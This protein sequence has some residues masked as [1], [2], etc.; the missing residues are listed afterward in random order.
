MNSSDGHADLVLLRRFE[1][2]IRFNRGELFYPVDV[3]V[4]LIHTD[5]LL[6]R[7]GED[8]TVLIPRPHATQEAIAGCDKDIYAG[9]LHLRLVDRPLNTLQLV[10][11]HARSDLREFRKGVTRH[12]RVGLVA[13]LL[14]VVFR[15]SLLVRGRV[16]G[17][18]AAAAA[19]TYEAMRE[20][21]PSPV[22]YGRVERTHDYTSLQYW[23]F[24][25]YND[26]RS[27]FHGA[28]DH[29]G[30]WEM[31]SVFLSHNEG[32]API[33]EWAAFAAHDGKGADL[34]RRWDDPE[35]RKVGEHPIV[36]AGAG[37]HAAHFSPG[38]YIIRARIPLLARLERAIATVKSVW[39]TA[40][41]QGGTSRA[42]R[43]GH[44]DVA[45]VDYARGDGRCIGPGTEI[46]W[47]ARLLDEQPAL[48]HYPGLWGRYLDDPI[49]GEDAPA[50]PR[51]NRDGSVRTAWY[52]PVGWSELTA[53]PSTSR[54]IPAAQAE[55]TR[56]NEEAAALGPRI[57]RAE[58]EATRLGVRVAAL[59]DGSPS[60]RH[61]DEC[62]GRLAEAR[63][64]V[65]R[66][67]HSLSETELLARSI[68]TRVERLK[69]G[70]RG[71]PRAHLRRPDVPQQ[72]S[73]LRLHRLAETWSAI[74][75]GLLLLVI[76]TV[77]IVYHAALLPFLLLFAAFLF[78]ESL[79]HR[80]V[81]AL[82]HG[83]VMTLALT[84]LAVLAYEF[85]WQIAV[86]LALGLGAAIT[87]TNLRELTRR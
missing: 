31:V 25:A 77:T 67:R 58:D 30:D 46:P 52:D 4:F 2:Q 35:L 73:Q 3:D 59:R 85:W 22:Y 63:E 78:V 60:S 74:S 8:P 24:Y 34:R 15:I 12:A 70:D 40:L 18:T 13:R 50:G 41:R 20:T 80:R 68:G 42:E 55:L 38:E 44:L 86:A 61:L 83:I 66:L 6:H 26:Y 23:F 54:E 72:P 76:G 5:L 29:E 7:R 43:D 65:S 69:Q 19:I 32:G 17:G 62:E 82:V 11:F 48:V 49:R 56:L 14:D 16:P 27:H 45:F 1:P 37:S 53:E 36:Y 71:D 10:Q 57:A 28:N 21:A 39:R 51:F 9:A 64:T 33:P 47:E 79:F 81:A 87:W 75:A 84:A